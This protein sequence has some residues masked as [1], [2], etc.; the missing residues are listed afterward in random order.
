MLQFNPE[1]WRRG[2]L[3][4]PGEGKSVPKSKM[5]RP[6]SPGCKGDLTSGPPPH[7]QP[8]PII[9]LSTAKNGHIFDLTGSSVT[10]GPQ[11]TLKGKLKPRRSK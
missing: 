4:E 2:F 6:R 9:H 7:G 1:M 11:S 5:I 10:W 3:S 8:S